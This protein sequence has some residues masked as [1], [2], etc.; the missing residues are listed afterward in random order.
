MAVTNKQWYN[1]NAARSFPL[2]E[3]ALLISDSGESVPNNVITD[4]SIRFPK[5]AGKYVY[6]SDMSVTANGLVT[7]AFIAS[8][9]APNVV[10]CSEN[11][12]VSESIESPATPILAVSLYQPTIGKCYSLQSQYPGAGG[13]IVFGDGIVDTPFIFRSTSSTR[14]LVSP[15]AATWTTELPVKGLSKPYA[16]TRL[17]GLINLKAGNDIEIVREC[18]EIPSGESPEPCDDTSTQMRNVIVVRLKDTGAAD[19]ARNVYDVYKGPCG[20]RPESRTCDDPQPIEFISGV[21]PD[22]CGVLTIELRGC[23]VPGKIVSGAAG[24]ILDC[25]LGLSDVCIHP[26]HLPDADGVLPNE[27]E[28]DCADAVSELDLCSSEA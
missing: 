2:D 3:S 16:Q 15:K 27:Y 23:A 9:T 18:R 4:L 17:T 13:C 12:E 28:G 25:G 22:C 7:V 11:S 8:D 21:G 1:L 5:S 26:T 19:T 10:G 6:L 14:T 24:V 20:G